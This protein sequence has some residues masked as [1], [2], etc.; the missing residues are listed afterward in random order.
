MTDSQRIELLSGLPVRDLINLTELISIAHVSAQ[1]HRETTV[2]LTA[3]KYGDMLN[4]AGEWKQAQALRGLD[5]TEYDTLY[6][7][8][9]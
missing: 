4:K 7:N 3:Q 2:I 8:A 6:Q 1:Q 5:D 9:Q